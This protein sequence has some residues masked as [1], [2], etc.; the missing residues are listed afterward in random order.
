MYRLPV[1]SHQLQFSNAATSTAGLAKSANPSQRNRE[2]WLKDL[3]LHK[4]MKNL[5]KFSDEQVMCCL[6]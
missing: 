4:Y 2:A 3:R 1:Q 5:E 6:S